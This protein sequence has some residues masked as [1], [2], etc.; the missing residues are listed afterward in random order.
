MGGGVENVY[1]KKF[2]KNRGV[3][4]VY[5][6]KFL[7]ENYIYNTTERKVRRVGRSPPPPRGPLDVNMINSVERY[8]VSCLF[9]FC[10]C[11]LYY[12]TKMAFIIY[13]YIHT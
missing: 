7:Y 1:T 6:Q 12:Y 5:T 3:E 4:N 11:H 10:F 13:I 8:M 9:N 2:L